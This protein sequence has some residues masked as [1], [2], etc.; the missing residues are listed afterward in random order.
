MVEYDN[1]FINSYKIHRPNSIHIF[2]DA[3]YVNYRKILDENYDLKAQC[4]GYRKIV[5]E[6]EKKSK[7][8]SDEEI[9]ERFLVKHGLLLVNQEVVDDLKVTVIEKFDWRNK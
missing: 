1:S 4:E 3:Q 6:L 8:L 9:V 2:N 5:K 7:P